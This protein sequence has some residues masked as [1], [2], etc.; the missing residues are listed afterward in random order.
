[1]LRLLW[2][3]A[4]VLI[5]GRLPPRRCL[6]AGCGTENSFPWAAPVSR[7]CKC[8]LC[9]K[10]CWENCECVRHVLRGKVEEQKEI[11]ALLTGDA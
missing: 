7:A 8:D 4:N 1:M 9:E 6:F 3:L 5:L 2:V 11:R 10:H